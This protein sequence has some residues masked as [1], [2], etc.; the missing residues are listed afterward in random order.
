MVRTLVPMAHGSA[1]ST[2]TQPALPLSQRLLPRG[3]ARPE[4]AAIVSAA[5]RSRL[6]SGPAHSFLRSPREMAESIAYGE[7]F[8][9]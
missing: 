1:G 5:A 3:A 7:L 2:N 6:T 8:P 4:G 9:E